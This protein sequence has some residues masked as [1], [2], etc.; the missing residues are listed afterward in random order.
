MKS[1][2]KK[3][4]PNNTLVYIKHIRT[5]LD[6][7]KNYRYDLKRFAKSAYGLRNIYTK[8][9]LRSK[10]TFHYHAIEKG[11]SNANI[12]YNFG[13][14]AFEQLFYSM[15]KYIKLGFPTEDKRFQSAVSVI[16]AYVDL[17]KE[18]N[19]R[20]FKVENKLNEYLPKFEEENIKLGGYEVCHKSNL[21]NYNEIPFNILAEK[22][23]S[24]REFGTERINQQ[25]VLDSIQIATKSPSV[26]NRQ[27]W[28]VYYLKELNLIE[29]VLKIQGGFKGNGQ[30]LKDLILIT[31]DNQFMNDS[32]ERNQAYI[33]GGLFTMSLIYGLESK[34]L[35]TCTLN[36]NFT[37]K[38]DKEIRKLLDINISENFI[39]FI[40][41]GTYP[42]KFK[43]AKSPR[44]NA[45]IITKIIN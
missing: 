17:H 23:Y 29:K 6:L 43:I 8:N 22:R 21:P 31:C 2:I 28:N 1:I 5:V 32:R 30:N 38:K 42:E 3:I 27:S 10:I 16:Q 20:N 12:R 33:D 14:T 18:N 39:A 40:A 25:D 24:I 36:T 4:I 11:L 15:D 13:E 19:L 9:N 34:N 35:A 45:E 7:K 41:V 26:C 44:D 37:I